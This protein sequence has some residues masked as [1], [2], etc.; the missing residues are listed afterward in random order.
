M[1]RI[2]SHK[3]NVCNKEEISSIFQNT[4][5]DG[6]IHLAAVSRVEDAENDKEKCVQVNYG[7]TKNIVDCIAK[8][9]KTWMIFGSSREVYGEQEIFPVVEMTDLCPLNVYGHTKLEGEILTQ[10][11]HKYMILRFSNVYG[12]SYDRQERVIPTFVRQAKNNE[13]LILHGGAQIID[14]TF[15]DDTIETIIRCINYLT[16]HEEVKEILHIS[17]GIENKLIDVANIIVKQF[18][19]KSQ[20]IVEPM[21]KRQYDVVRFWGDSNKRKS[22]LGNNEFKSITSGIKMMSANI[23]SVQ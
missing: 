20:I 4:F 13:P 5:F 14:F 7:G 12:N 1:S 10:T 23:D 3:A 22:L 18:K 11:L 8:S 17:P 19:S 21:M 15:I 2:H 6:V 16:V 9:P